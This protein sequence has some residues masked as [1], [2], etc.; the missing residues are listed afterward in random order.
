MAK[1]KVI[2]SIRWL[3]SFNIIRCSSSDSTT[4]NKMLKRS[5]NKTISKKSQKYNCVGGCNTL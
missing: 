2:E 1:V 4:L 5:N 3:V